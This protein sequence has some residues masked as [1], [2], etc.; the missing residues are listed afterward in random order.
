M[1]H[2]Q[3]ASPGLAPQAL[4]RAGKPSPTARRYVAVFYFF[5]NNGIMIY[6]GI[7]LIKILCLFH[8]IFKI[9]I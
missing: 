3:F 8:D 9:A 6:C 4:I 7:Y 5:L 1:L 2:P